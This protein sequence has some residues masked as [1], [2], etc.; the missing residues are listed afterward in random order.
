MWQ[1]FRRIGE[2][3]RGGNTRGEWFE[4]TGRRD[5]K[6][7]RPGTRITS[8]NLYV[9]N[10]TRATRSLWLD[11]PNSKYLCGLGPP[12][13]IPPVSL[14]LR[15]NPRLFVTRSYL[16]A[17][18]SPRSQVR[19]NIG[20]AVSWTCSSCWCRASEQILRWSQLGHKYLYILKITSRDTAS[21]TTIL[22]VVT[23]KYTGQGLQGTG[24]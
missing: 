8:V 18:E 6:N 23:E 11:V 19:V 16:P 20:L 17:Y 1:A 24:N 21:D 14:L 22:W 12:H 4:P 5:I 15:I 9:M 2:A 7:S 13:I 3:E 10:P